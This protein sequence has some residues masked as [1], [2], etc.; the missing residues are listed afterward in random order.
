MFKSKFAL[1]LA[2]MAYRADEPGTDGST[3]VAPEKEA[4]A[5]KVERIQANGVTRP[6]D[7]TVTGRVWEISDRLSKA[8]GK[9]VPRAD[10]MKEAV[11]GGINSAT[12]A[13]QY[14][15]WRVFNGL[16]GVVTTEPKPPKE[17]KAKGP[18]T[19]VK[20]DT[21]AAAAAEASTVEG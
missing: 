17:K 4:K 9:P 14:G 7:G 21:A 1:S 11:E 20:N 16:K 6:A 13:T 5:P 15:K 2:A 19:T 12:V 10:V 8:L 3:A 18:K